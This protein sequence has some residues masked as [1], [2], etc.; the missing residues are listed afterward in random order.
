MQYHVPQRRPLHDVLVCIREGCTIAEAGYRLLSNA[1]AYLKWPDEMHHIFARC[2]QAIRRQHE[3][4]EQCTF[5]LKQLRYEY[6]VEL[7]PE[8]KTAI[9][10]LGELTWAGAKKRYPVGM[11]DKVPQTLA[12]ELEII[13]RLKYEPYFLTVHDL[14]RFARS[15]GILCQG[16]GSAANSA[17]CY[18]LGVTNVD[19]ARIDV[20]FERFVSSARDEP[21]DID[22]DFEHER[23][24]EVIQYVYEK[25]GRER[26]GMTAEV[27]TYRGRSAVRDVGKALGLSLDVVNQMAKRLD[28]WDR[29]TLPDT[30]SM[31]C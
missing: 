18:C 8:G 12:R 25:Y 29:G 11:P 13:E 15:K 9:E 26:A 28:W 14:V 16:R 30:Q 20:L 3:I 2:P 7:V 19:P 27:I 10:Y 31:L 22:I 5:N 1:E 23:R 17:V 24:E 6:P 21:P 4:V